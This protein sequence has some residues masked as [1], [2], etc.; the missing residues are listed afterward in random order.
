MKNI[1]KIFGI[2]TLAAATAFSVAACQDNSDDLTGGVDTPVTFSSVTANGSSS[3]TTTQLTLT[4][5]KAI[6]DLTAAD[7]T[8]SGVNGVSKGNLS[9]SGPS[10]TLPISGF[11]SGGT[12]TV[13]AAKTGYTV[14]GSP[15]QVTIYRAS[16]GGNQNSLHSNWQFYVGAAAPG[17]AFTAS[18]G[19]YPLLKHFNVLVAENDMKPESVMPSQWQNWQSNPAYNASQAYRWDNADKLVSYAKANNTKIRGHVLFWHE[20][21]PNVFFTTGNASAPLITKEVLYQRMEQHVK[22]V[23]QKYRGDILW[24]D[25]ANECVGD[26][27]NPRTTGNANIAGSDGTSGF[28]AVMANAGVSGDARYDWIVEAFKYARQYADANGGQNVKLF[29]TEYGIEESSTKLNGLLRL[30]DYLISNGAPIDGVGI[31]GHARIGTGNGNSYVN[32]L[33][34]AID[35]ITTRKNPVN[36]NNLVVQVC[37]LD[38]SLFAWNDSTLTLSGSVLNSRLQAQAVMYRN[39][40]DMFAL[41][42]SAGKL[43]MVLV[44]GLADGESWLNGFPTA[45]R[46][47]HPLLFDRQYQP[48]AAFNALLNESVGG[49]EPAETVVGSFNAYAGNQHID[50]SSSSAY[51]IVNLTVESRTNVMKVTNPSEF[52]AALYSLTAH[53][54]TQITITFSADVKRVGAAGTLNWQVNNDPGYPSVGTPI[55]NAAAGTWHAMSGSWTGTPTNDNPSF[56]LSTYQNNSDSTTYYIDNFTITITP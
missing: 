42:H 39:L 11:T 14:S 41:K 9:G 5:S 26:D 56:Y 25:V 55:S 33:G 12:L 6:T 49:G 2:I 20:Q 52:A 36:Q 53:K 51:Q 24:W 4:F 37:E 18:N 16:G 48:K 28:T 40:F 32:G 15:K 10:Y 17:S 23:F 50:L 34:N 30:V 44:W 3:Q 27:G 35:A 8:L 54:N 31:Q 22:T 19:Q 1:Q 45:G 38:I 29:L 21:I 43:D 46:E 7:I 13:A 47:D